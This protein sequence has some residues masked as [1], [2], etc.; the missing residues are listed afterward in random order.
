MQCL[1]SLSVGNFAAKIESEEQRYRDAVLAQEDDKK[2]KKD[3]KDAKAP[4]L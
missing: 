1:G 2:D 4:R 3:K